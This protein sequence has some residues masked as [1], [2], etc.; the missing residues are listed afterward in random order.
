ML[1][2]ACFIEQVRRM[3]ELIDQGNNIQGFLA[4]VDIDQCVA[5]R[6]S[7]AQDKDGFFFIHLVTSPSTSSLQSTLSD[8]RDVR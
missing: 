4:R 5:L 7:R 1:N 6:G 2:G 3:E 8:S